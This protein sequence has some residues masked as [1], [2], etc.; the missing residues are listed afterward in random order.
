MNDLLKS[1]KFVALFLFRLLLL[2]LLLFSLKQLQG[3]TGC[4]IFHQRQA[5]SVQC[6]VKLHDGK[7][8]TWFIKQKQ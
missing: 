5:S 2:M 1:L 3:A 4:R 8:R 6:V 7:I